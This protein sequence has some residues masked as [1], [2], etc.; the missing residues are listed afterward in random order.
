VVL[1]NGLVVL[2]Q[3]NHANPTVAITGILKA[4]GM[5]DPKDKR[6]LANFTAGLLDRGTM[7]HTFQ[8]IAEQID[9]I[10]ASLNLEAT[11]ETISFST[12]CLSDNFEQTLNLVGNILLHPT[13]PQKEIEKLRGEI[14]TTLKEEEENPESRSQLEFY[15]L[16]YPWEHPYHQDSLRAE[17]G[18]RQVSQADILSFYGQYYR[19]DS[20]ILVVVGNVS[21]AEIQEKVSRIFGTWTAHGKKL[22]FSIPN[23]P[24]PE[25]P[26]TYVVN[27]ENKAEVIVRLGH[28]G[29]ARGNPD[30]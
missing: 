29:I 21:T 13:F 5:Y 19:P 10:G 26:Q 3:E 23:I 4:G 16:L 6:G 12:Y 24:L 11:T 25:K 20:T 17:E 22:P 14:L 30:Y 27:M 9:F 7:D 18:I 28:T 2:T 15:S 8:E 1:S